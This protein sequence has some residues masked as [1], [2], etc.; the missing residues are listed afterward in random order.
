MRKILPALFFLLAP[1]Y[2][3][4]QGVLYQL[5]PPA[6]NA[7]VLVC[8]SPDNGYP[9]PVTANIFSDSGLTQAISQ[10]VSLGSSG[11]FSFYISAGTYTIQLTGPGYNSSNRQVVSISGGGVTASSITPRNAQPQ[12]F[13]VVNYGAKGDTQFSGLG[14]TCTVSNGVNTITCPNANFS[15]AKDIGKR[16]N[17]GDSPGGGRYFTVGSTITGVNSSTVAV[18]SSNAAAGSSA[19]SCYWGT[20][21]DAPGG[22]I[23]TAVAAWQAAAST[24]N[25]QGGAFN[26]NNSPAAPV[27]YFPAGAYLVCG[28]TNLAVIN[29]P[30]NK[31]GMVIEGDAPQESVLVPCDNLANSGAQGE[32]I[33]QPSGANGLVIKN[34]SVDGMYMPANNN[35]AIV[36]GGIHYTENVTVTRWSIG[37]GFDSNGGSG[38]NLNIQV[39]NSGG[40]GN[41]GLRCQNCNDEFHGG[42]S[43]NNTSGN[44]L[45]SNSSGL[46]NAQ[47]PRFTG[48]FFV[49]E[50]GSA[51]QCF[52][53]VNTHDLWLQGIGITGTPSGVGL[54]VDGNSSVHWNGGVAAVF[55]TDTNTGGVTVDAGGTLLESDV[56]NVSTGTAKCI[57]NNG[58]L[59]DNGGN[60]CESMFRI[61]S[62]T[63]TGTTAVLTLTTAGAAVNVACAAGDSLEV[64]S[65]TI[66]GY[67]GY[68]ASGA[69]TAVTAT[70]LTYTTQGS[71]LGALGAGGVAF[72]KNLINYSGNLPKALLNN[73]V[74]NTCYVTGTF[75][76]TVTGAPMCAFKTQSATNVT[77]IKAASTTVTACT[78]APVVTISDGTVSVTLTLT[79]AKSLW[80]SSVDT[81]TGVGTTIFKP[82][83]TIQVTNTVG[84][85]T[86]PPTNF[87]VSYNVSP[88]LS[89]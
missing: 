31:F 42:G 57:T 56:R 28:A 34:I 25:G 65:A 29:T 8:P 75:G 5:S 6:P 58:L 85:C 19:V 69:I 71:N 54:H 2:S 3:A 77:N 14:A 62:G 27:L 82:N 22:P 70:T 88:I 73:P 10:P 1:S 12:V 11:F 78:V 79:T 52:N 7:R 40:G 55:G 80:D 86:T 59:L 23:A 63:S 41:T 33:N 89:N 16:A 61:A 18:L 53:V 47:G 32:I 67:N 60:T 37:Q 39:N 44:V 30:N 51:A 72:C 48:N 76:A 13:N 17:C 20:V 49:D 64:Q 24:S 81:S 21:D 68:F 35:A 15:A 66:A 9:C 50:C 38:Y 74:P 45:V 4:A 26:N 83:G 43:S 84:T 87:S 36:L 46:N